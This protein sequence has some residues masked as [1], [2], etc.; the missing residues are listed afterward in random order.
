M[1]AGLPEAMLSID[2]DTSYFSS[3]P[4]LEKYNAIGLG[5]GLGTKQQSHSAL[6]KLLD[7]W[8]KPIVI[9]ADALNILAAHPEAIPKIPTGSILTPH[10]KEFERLLGKSD[11]DFKRYELQMEFAVKYQLV[12]ILKGAHTAIATPDGHCY[13]N[14]SGNPGMATGGSGDVLTGIITALLAQGYTP[15]EAA[16]LGVYIHGLSA[17]LIVAERAAESLIAGDLVEG[18]A[19]AFHELHAS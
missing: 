12:L 13:F 17:D 19:L 9:D 18:L 14:S 4:V 10:P 16:C 11:D 6:L 3:L 15:V 1:Q 8:D 2:K 7:V 5:P